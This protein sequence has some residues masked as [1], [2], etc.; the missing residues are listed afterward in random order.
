MAK[1]IQCKKFIP[2]ERAELYGTC[3]NCTPQYKYLAVEDGQ[4]KTGYGVNGF[5][6]SDDA[7]SVRRLNNTDGQTI[8]GNRNMHRGNK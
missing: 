4:N 5:V 2:E 1:C 8:I 3:I 6:R 7:E